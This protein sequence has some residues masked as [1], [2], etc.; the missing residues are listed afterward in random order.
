VSPRVLLVSQPTDGGC[1]TCVRDLA[2]AA[3]GDGWDVKVATPGG[4]LAEWLRGSSVEVVPVQLRREPHPSDLSAALR[5]RALM[6]DADV[7]HLHSSKAAAVGRLARLTLRDPPPCLFTPH[8]WS[9]SVG[10]GLASA[11]RFLE[12]VLARAATTIIAV[13]DEEARQGEAVL[14]RAAR[15]RLV[16]IPNGVDVRRFHPEGKAATRPE[17][18]LVVVLGRLDRAKGPDIAVEVLARLGRPAVLRL[19]G[20]GPADATVRRRAR[21]LGVEDRVELVGLSDVPAEHLRAADVVLIPSRWEAM[22]LTMLEAFAC[23][24]PVVMTDVP[25]SSVGAGVATIVPTGAIEQLATA[26]NAV[27][28]DP[29]RAADL[30]SRARERV[31]AHYEL[32]GRLGEVM[33]AWRGALR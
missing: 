12:R 21:E 33:S 29:A 28:D 16:V 18:P 9:W 5:L 6:R 1:A 2:L 22:S 17:A 20:D 13:S 4:L 26:V 32:Q 10:G 27:L 30:G 23:A 8:G 15:D 24:R 14:G 25:G 3:A 31:V 11:Y 7:V 19:V